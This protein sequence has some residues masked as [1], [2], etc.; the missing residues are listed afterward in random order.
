MLPRKLALEGGQ[1]PS[2]WGI[3]TTWPSASE[4]LSLVSGPHPLI[5]PLVDLVY[6]E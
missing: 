2:M 5:C 3:S 4:S 1:P 6:S